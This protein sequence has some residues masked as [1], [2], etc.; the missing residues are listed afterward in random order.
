MIEWIIQYWAQALFGGGIFT[1]LLALIKKQHEQL[2][3]SFKGY[4]SLQEG[5]SLL[6]EEREVVNIKLEE[7]DLLKASLRALLKDR[8]IQSYNHYTDKGYIP[9]YAHENIHN[10]Y[11]QYE[12]LG[13]NGTICN[14]I[15]SIDKLPKRAEPKKDDGKCF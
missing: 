4:H 13:G 2:K 10:L 11:A 6:L 7:H 5:V 12:N 15:N 1:L 14:L 3:K 8:I 9:I